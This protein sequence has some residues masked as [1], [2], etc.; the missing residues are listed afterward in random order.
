MVSTSRQNLSLL[1][2]GQPQ[3]ALP[4]AA[5]RLPGLKVCPDADTAVELA[6][7]GSFAAI[8]VVMSSFPD[9]LPQLIGDLHSANGSSR[10]FLLARMYEEPQAMA[11]M[12]TS[13][14][15]AGPFLADYLICPAD[16]DE[17]LGGA[18]RD[19]GADT[20][21]L[22]LPVSAA[23]DL[24]DELV[25][26]ATEDYLTGLKNRRYF[27]EFLSQITGRASRTSTEVTL[28]VLDIDGLKHYNDTWGHNVGDSVL[29]Q[30][31]TFI[32]NCCRSHDLVARI[33]G[34]EFA[35]VFWD[36][37]AS[38]QG[39][40]VGDD[41]R[42]ACAVHPGETDIIERFR[43]RL[44]GAGLPL[45]G[46]AGIGTLTMSGG[47]ARFPRDGAGTAELLLAADK[48]LLQAKRSGKNL[49]YLVG[50]GL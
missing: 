29:R 5:L 47:L 30:A 17:I 23:P 3:G 19:I 25:R 9:N 32:K 22:S 26:M 10:L 46:P 39:G 49:I 14:N 18:S 4:S 24:M 20:G 42:A 48:A 27:E 34:D 36:V 44:V 6:A 12:N 1:I 28:V 43:Q 8:G 38:G 35:V 50:Q 45:L 7:G 13:R 2:V 15:G 33:G 41:R 40:Q 31:A 37:P 16:P 21:A 11:L